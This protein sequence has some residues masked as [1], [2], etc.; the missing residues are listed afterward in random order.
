MVIDG[1]N[2]IPFRGLPG[3]GHH[4]VLPF[5]APP[6]PERGHPGEIALVGIVKDL[7]G[8]QTVTDRFNRLFF[9]WYAGLGL[10]MGC[11]GR[12]KTML[13]ALRCTRTVSA[14]PRMPGCSAI[15][16][17]KRARG[18]QRI[19]SPETAGPQPDY[20]KQLRDVCRSDCLGAP[21][22]LPSCM[23]YIYPQCANHPF[24]S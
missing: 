14:S 7:P 12:L 5:R 3:R 9:T 8:L 20:V 18:P 15:E 6:G 22:A 24:A 16:S 17:A 21:R 23:Y 13:A 19:R 4:H 1:T 10:V 2:A 11:W